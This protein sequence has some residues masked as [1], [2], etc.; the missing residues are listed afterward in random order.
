MRIGIMTWF[1]YENYGTVL[2]LY[3]LSKT[4]GEMGDEPFVINYRTKAHEIIWERNQIKERVVKRVERVISRPIHSIERRK[5]FQLFLDE[6]VSFTYRCDTL[7]EL[8]GLNNHIDAFVC[9]S[10]QIWSPIAFDPHYFLDFVVDTKR[11]IA[12]APSIGQSTIRN[13]RI[14]EEIKLKASRIEHLSVREEQGGSILSELTE[15]S[16]STVLDPTL[17][18]S[19]KEWS[20]LHGHCSRQRE[21]Y[22][23]VYMLRNRARHWKAIYEVKKKLGCEIRII[24][25]FQLDLMRRGCIKEPIGPKEFIELFENASFVCTDSYHGMLFAIQYHVDFCIFERF[26][27]SETNNQNS[28]IYSLLDI[29]GLRRRMFTNA[30]SIE[31]ILDDMIDWTRLDAV[32]IE[33]KAQSRLYLF[34]AIESVRRC[35]KQSKKKCPLEWCREYVKE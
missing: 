33:R 15:R 24:P 23:L 26:R 14:R 28:R 12:Y 31:S 3:A 27:F 21:P 11:T 9:G 29:L 5:L 2:Q 18:I 13:P 30:N 7:S 22:V 1:Q 34:N 4:I 16:V 8:K 35:V 25:V 17:L 20:E 32:L 6:N 10:D 19:S